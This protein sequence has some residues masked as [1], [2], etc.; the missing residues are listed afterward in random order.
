MSAIPDDVLRDLVH[1]V[2]KHVARIARNVPDGE[3]SGHLHAL[4]CGDLFG[5]DVRA[6]P[7]MRF[8]ELLGESEIAELRDVEAWLRRIDAIEALVRAGEAGAI[9]EAVVHARRIDDA[10]RALLRERVGG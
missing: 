9:A 6:R 8:S 5:D 10:L 2:G 4:L 3:V 7:S 1:D